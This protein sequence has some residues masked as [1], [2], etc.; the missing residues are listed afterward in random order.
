MTHT[1]VLEKFKQMFPIYF[2]GATIWFPNGR[3]SIRV[4][5]PDHK[6]LVFTYNKSSDWALETCDRFIMRLKGE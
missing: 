6:D 4:R 2:E 1:A 5:Q 3:N